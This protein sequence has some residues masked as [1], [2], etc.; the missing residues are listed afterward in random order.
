MAIAFTVPQLEGQPSRYNLLVSLGLFIFGFW[1]LAY[2]GDVIT[3]LLDKRLGFLI[4]KQEGLRGTKTVRRSLREISRITIDEIAQYG[5]R[6]NAGLCVYK[7]Y[8]QLFNGEQ[9]FLSTNV[10]HNRELVQQIAKSICKF[11]ALHPHAITEVKPRS[12]FS[13]R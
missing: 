6:G 11:L 1:Q 9:I 12:F 8:L 13:K 5:S 3:C 10:L 7:I 4:L 2:R